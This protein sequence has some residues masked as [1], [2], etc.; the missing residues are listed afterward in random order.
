[1]LTTPANLNCRV[2]HRKVY[3]FLCIISQATNITQKKFSTRNRAGWGGDRS[4]LVAVCLHSY[5]YTTVDHREPYGTIEN[6]KESYKTKSIWD[7]MGPCRTL[8]NLTRSSGSFW[9]LTS[10]YGSLQDLMEPYR[11][12]LD[13]MGPHVSQ[14]V[15]VIA[16]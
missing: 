14:F 5:E 6:H 8:W 15:Q 1:M 2:S 16:T 9:V 10:P 12:L 13:L 7:H 11:T 4:I 3:L